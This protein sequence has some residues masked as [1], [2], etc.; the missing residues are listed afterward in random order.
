LFV[1]DRN[2]I[3]TSLT[4]RCYLFSRPQS[5]IGP[6][7]LIMLAATCAYKQAHVTD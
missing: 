7:E 5:E 6:R 3:M 2:E 1:T 4:D